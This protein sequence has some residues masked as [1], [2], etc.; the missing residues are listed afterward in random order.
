MA[1]APS[2]FWD[3]KSKMISVSRRERTKIKWK[4]ASYSPRYNHSV[5]CVRRDT[6]L[7]RKAIVNLPIVP[8]N[9]QKFRFLKT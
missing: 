9:H 1:S 8:A 3:M 4:I 6:R 7:V 5:L 2:V